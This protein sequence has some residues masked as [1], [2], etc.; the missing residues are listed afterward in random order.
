MAGKNVRTGTLDEVRLRIC[1]TNGDLVFSDIDTTTGEDVCRPVEVLTA[2]AFAMLV[3]K[4]GV[5][6]VV[7]A[8]CESLK[9]A[10][11]L[12]AITNVIGTRD[13]VSPGMFAAWVENFYGLL[14]NHPLSEAFDYAVEASRAPMKLYAMQE[15]VMTQ[16]HGAVS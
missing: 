14:P 1:P 4:R 2:E 8:S 11:R 3:K 10:E 5:R 12:R 9:L 7:I 15:L 6:L 16:A 13:M